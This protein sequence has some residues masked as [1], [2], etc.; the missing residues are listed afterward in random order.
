MKTFGVQF[1]K[2]TAKIGKGCEIVYISA[3]LAQRYPD[4]CLRL[5]DI[6]NKHNVPFAFLLD[7]RIFGA[8][9]IC[10]FRHRVANWFS[11]NMILLT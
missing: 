11:S 8:G 6:L 4:T 3:L 9:T 7:T 1:P 2:S 10:R 5:T